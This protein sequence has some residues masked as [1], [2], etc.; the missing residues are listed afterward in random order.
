LTTVQDQVRTDRAHA[1]VRPVQPIHFSHPVDGMPSP[2]EQFPHDRGLVVTFHAPAG[3]E[4]SLV[5]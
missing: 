3:S 2:R 4:L 1:V 5:A